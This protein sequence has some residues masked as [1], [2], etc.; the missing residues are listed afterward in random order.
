MSLRVA[1]FASGGGSNLQA[2]LDHF[3]PQKSAPAEIA[4]VISDREDAGALKRAEAAG[5]PAS[6]VST[7]RRE[8]AAVAEE[9]LAALALQRIDLI[10]LAGYL[11][12]VPQPVVH[13]FRGRILNVHPALLPA[14]GGKGMYGMNVHRAVLAAGC[15]VTGATIHHVDENYDEGRIV[16]QWPVPVLQGDT[17]EALAARVLRVEHMLYPA[18]LTLVARALAGG[19]AKAAC[20]GF[21]AALAFAT[22]RDEQPAADLIRTTL[23][24]D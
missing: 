5:V 24:L 6:V 18:A 13:A 10:A 12:L 15:F 4:L 21:P 7:T 11:R 1:V 9:T 17:A 2:L 20:A 8:P 22:L 14:F 3:Q 16:A 23:G 19:T